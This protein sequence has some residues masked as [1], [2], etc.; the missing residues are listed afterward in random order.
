MG[1]W[2]EGVIMAKDEFWVD[3]NGTRRLANDEELADIARMTSF[4]KEQE[5][6]ETN[7]QLAKQALLNKLGITADEAKLLLQ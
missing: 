2:I 1:L 3:D 5:T 6:I 4:R 7:K